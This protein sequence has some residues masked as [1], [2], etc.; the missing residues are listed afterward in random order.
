[1]AAALARARG[2]QRRRPERRAV[3]R[4]AYRRC[5]ASSCPTAPRPLPRDS[6]LTSACA[7]IAQ[8]SRRALRPRLAGSALQPELGAEHVFM[9][10][11]R[12]AAHPHRVQRLRR[13]RHVPVPGGEGAGGATTIASMFTA[14]SAPRPHRARW[15]PDLGAFVRGAK[16]ADD[17]PLTAFV[18]VFADPPSMGERAVRT[19]ALDAASA[20]ARPRRFGPPP[21]IQP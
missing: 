17:D 3:S 7:S 11:D 12:R 13:R 9:T 14:P 4:T 5:A 2:G 20:A 19:P 8:A 15:R 21:G 16:R 18:A 10:A 6:W 1:M